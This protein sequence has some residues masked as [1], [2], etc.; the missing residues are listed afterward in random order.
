MTAN[1]E[2]V[3]EVPQASIISIGTNN[4]SVATNAPNSSYCQVATNF[5]TQAKFLGSY[6]IPLV[7]VQISGTFQSLSGPQILANYNAPNALVAPSLG[8]PISG[9]ISGGQA[10]VTVNLVE[11]GTMYGD[12][13]NQLNLRFAKLLRFGRLRTSPNVDLYNALNGSPVITQNNNFGAW[14]TPTSILLARFVKLSVQI[15]F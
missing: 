14:Q 15:D 2:I 5:L 6:L 4:L 1:C 7:D 8:R 13:L 11:P 9:P 10:N 3:A 12:R